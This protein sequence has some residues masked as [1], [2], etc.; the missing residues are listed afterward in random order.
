MG[1][2]P[3]LKSMTLKDLVK[4]PT[5]SPPIT[6]IKAAGNRL[7]DI[8][9]RVTIP[10]IIPR[11][12][13]AEIPQNELIT[14]VCSISNSGFKTKPIPLL[15]KISPNPNWIPLTIGFEKNLAIQLI[16]PVNESS[17]SITPKVKPDAAKTGRVIFAGKAIAIAETTFNG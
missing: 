8:K 6:I 17:N 2:G 12:K 16:R 4:R 14:P 5:I 1:V 13:L 15:I 3:K 10:P 9:I 7:F 11:S